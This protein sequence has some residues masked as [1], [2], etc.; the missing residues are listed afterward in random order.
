MKEQTTIKNCLTC[1]KDLIEGSTI[2]RNWHMPICNSCREIL[3]NYHLN[4]DK[5]DRIIRF[6]AKVLED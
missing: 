3:L 6:R 5:I 2:K 4:K 1:N